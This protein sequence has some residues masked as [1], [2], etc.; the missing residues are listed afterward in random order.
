MIE[1]AMYVAIPLS[2]A[3]QNDDFKVLQQALAEV[4]LIPPPRQTTGQNEVK[5]INDFLM[6]CTSN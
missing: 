1:L 4:T 3:S 5:Y 6:T 2:I